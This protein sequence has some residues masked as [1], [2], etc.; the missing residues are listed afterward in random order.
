MQETDA[1]DMGDPVQ[2]SASEALPDRTRGP[3]R[4]PT[5]QARFVA[6]YFGWSLTGDSI[7]DADDAVA[8]YIE[9]LAAALG[10]LGWIAPDGIRWDRLPFGEDDA[11]DALRAVQRARGWDV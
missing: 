9:D 4:S 1:G 6:G 5:E 7:R 10:E 2:A 11:A 3:V 8:L